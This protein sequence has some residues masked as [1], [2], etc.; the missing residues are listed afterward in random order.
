MNENDIGT[1]IQIYCVGIIFGVS[2]IVELRMNV[3]EKEERD[4]RSRETEL[5]FV[6]RVKIHGPTNIC[7]L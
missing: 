6:C 5:L 7:M 4:A 2:G 1:Y 3:F